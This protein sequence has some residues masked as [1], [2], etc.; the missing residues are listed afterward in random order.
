MVKIEL[1]TFWELD[2][3][4]TIQFS[5]LILN[6]AVV[7]DFMRRFEIFFSNFAPKYKFEFALRGGGVQN[8]KQQLKLQEKS[9]FNF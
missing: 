6:G 9:F 8:S 2:N 5:R 4:K 1:G 3:S 7:L